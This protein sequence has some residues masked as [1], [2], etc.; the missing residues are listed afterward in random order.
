MNTVNIDPDHYYKEKSRHA[1]A[2]MSPALRCEFRAEYRQLRRF[3]HCPRIIAQGVVN[4]LAEDI[5]IF[6]D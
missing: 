1:W 6:T 4:R 5:Q 2:A 3:G